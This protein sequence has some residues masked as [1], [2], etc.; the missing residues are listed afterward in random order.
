MGMKSQVSIF[1]FSLFVLQP[2]SSAK[3][4]LVL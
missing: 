1:F 3:T 2:G 4:V